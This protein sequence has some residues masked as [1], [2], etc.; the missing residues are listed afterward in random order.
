MLRKGARF[1]L[2]RR[3]TMFSR[4]KEV[5]FDDMI[6]PQRKANCPKEQCTSLEERPKFLQET[7]VTNLL[8]VTI[9]SYFLL[10]N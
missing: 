9:I 8:V 2:L 3:A 5:I 6:V 4:A 7:Y 1:E 10:Y